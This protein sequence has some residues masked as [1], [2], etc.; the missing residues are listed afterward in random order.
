[1]LTIVIFIT[2]KCSITCILINNY[3]LNMN[4]NANTNTFTYANILCII[5][6]VIIPIFVITSLIFYQLYC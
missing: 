4:V 6:V 3:V 1:M 2:T 5:V